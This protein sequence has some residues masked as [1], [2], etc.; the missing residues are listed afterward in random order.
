MAEPV[1]E[2]VENVEATDR[3]KAAGALAQFKQLS[4]YLDGSTVETRI[5][6]ELLPALGRA[7]QRRGIPPALAV[8]M[9][10]W[11]LATSLAIPACELARKEAGEPVLAALVARKA[12]QTG[13][14]L[15]GLETIEEQFNAAASLP[16]QF[17]LA[18]LEET[19]QLGARTDDV[20][21]TI[22]NLYANGDLAM[23]TPLMRHVSRQVGAAD[24]AID[25]RQRLV[26]DR[27]AVMA[28]RARDYLADGAVF[29]AVGAL[30]LPGEEGLVALLRE[31]GFTVEPVE[32]RPQANGKLN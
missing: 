26:H 5:D 24:N 11:L 2:P 30:H 31:R 7:A 10:P 4:F 13:K 20:M 27:N 9:G 25:F 32:I 6:E 29:M 15:V 1:F 19:L 22:K 23:I 28:E 8:R 18:A 12:E 3:A 16:E 14:R 17:H 21:A